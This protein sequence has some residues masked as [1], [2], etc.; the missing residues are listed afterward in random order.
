[1]E[2]SWIQECNTCAL[3]KD[4]ERWTRHLDNTQEK[5]IRAVAFQDHSEHTLG[6]HGKQ[7]I[8]HAAKKIVRLGHG[9]RSES[10]RIFK[11]PTYLLIHQDESNG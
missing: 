8:Q 2:Q 1:M 7:S 11:R 5:Q 9:R 3:G 4:T 10:N 6:V